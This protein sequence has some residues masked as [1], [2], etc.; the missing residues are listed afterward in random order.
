VCGAHQGPEPAVCGLAASRDALPSGGSRTNPK[1]DPPVGDPGDSGLRTRGPPREFADANG[2][3]LG[4]TFPAQ[5]LTR[6][7]EAG[8]STHRPES[9]SRHLRASDS[10]STSYQHRQ[11]HRKWTQRCCPS[12]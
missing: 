7:P 11:E 3:V 5:A 4:G 2:R 9:T 8:R 6:R 12:R 1:T 10:W